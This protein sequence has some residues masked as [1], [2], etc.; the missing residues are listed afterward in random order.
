MSGSRAKAMSG[1]VNA[2]LQRVSRLE[3]KAN[4]HRSSGLKSLRRAAFDW[5]GEHGFP[6]VKD[7]AW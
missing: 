7:E 1:T 5:V 3:S 6:T 2:F 4:G